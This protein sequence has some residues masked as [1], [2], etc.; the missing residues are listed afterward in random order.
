MKVC[1]RADSFQVRS[2]PAAINH[3]RTGRCRNPGGSSVVR[4][5]EGHARAGWWVGYW[6]V[7]REAAPR[8]S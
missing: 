8:A 3:T 4:R 2:P 1:R 6:V 5:V 7:T